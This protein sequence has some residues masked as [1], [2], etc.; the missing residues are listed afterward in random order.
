MGPLSLVERARSGAPRQCTRYVELV[1]SPPCVVS[2]SVVCPLKQTDRPDQKPG[3]TFLQPSGVACISVD[4]SS[5]L[6]DQARGGDRAV[7]FSSCRLCLI[8]SEAIDFD[9]PV[10]VLACPALFLDLLCY[11]QVNWLRLVWPGLAAS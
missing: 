1:P 11:A 8:V 10:L 3:P 5:C 2:V 7:D 9:S 6:P 4:V